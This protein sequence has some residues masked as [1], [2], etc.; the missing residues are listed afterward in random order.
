MPPTTHPHPLQAG[1]KDEARSAR[2]TLTH[3]HSAART[4]A[5]ANLIISNPGIKRAYFSQSV[6]VDSS[7]GSCAHVYSYAPAVLYH[8]EDGGYSYKGGCTHMGSG[9]PAG[10]GC[11]E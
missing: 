1:C 4:L 5:M 6:G 3:H 10:R 9:G 11:M 7:E 8:P 2:L